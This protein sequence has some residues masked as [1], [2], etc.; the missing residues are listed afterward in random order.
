M[1]LTGFIENSIRNMLYKNCYAFLFPSIFEGFG[2]PPIEAML[3]GATVVT[4]R[5]TSIP[6]VTQ[7]RANY[8]DNPFDER[9][10]IDRIKTA[11]NR[12]SEMDFKAYDEKKLAETY[13]NFLEETFQE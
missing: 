4:T 11:E 9:E 12:D 1:I 7:N 5:C 8:V 10:W 13:L 6:E 3:L 2:M